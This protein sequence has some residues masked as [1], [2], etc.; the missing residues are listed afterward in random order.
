[1]TRMDL[2]WLPVTSEDPTHSRPSPFAGRNVVI[3][4]ECALPTNQSQLISIR[5]GALSEVGS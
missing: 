1:M 2:N 5:M 3:S 4:L